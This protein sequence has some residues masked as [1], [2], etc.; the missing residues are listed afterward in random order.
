MSKY[1]RCKCGKLVPKVMM[2][3]H[4]CDIGEIIERKQARIEY[5]VENPSAFPLKFSGNVRQKE[6]AKRADKFCHSAGR[7]TAAERMKK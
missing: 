5:Y 2:T 7:E 6:Y 3:K 4:R 1:T